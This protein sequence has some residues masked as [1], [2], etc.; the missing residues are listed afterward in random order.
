MEN[1]ITKTANE[2]NPYADIFYSYINHSIEDSLEQV[3][4]VKTFLSDEQAGSGL[5]CT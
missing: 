5:P 4:S 3:R 1:K 2:N